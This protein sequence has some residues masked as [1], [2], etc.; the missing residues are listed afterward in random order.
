MVLFPTL[1]LLAPH[2]KLNACY[3]QVAPVDINSTQA[4]GECK[5]PASQWG[6]FY[7]YTT[8]GKTIADI[9]KEDPEWK[10]AASKI[11]KF[12]QD[13]GQK[14]IDYKRFLRCLKHDNLAM[15]YELPAANRRVSNWGF[16]HPLEDCVV[17]VE[18]DQEQKKAAEV[19]PY[20]EEF[21]RKLTRNSTVALL[22]DYEG[23]PMKN[24]TTLDSISQF[25]MDGPSGSADMQSFQDVHRKKR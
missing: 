16:N 5:V 12:V 9:I 14:R 22:Q 11:I 6:R 17:D 3:G 23:F 19:F 15:E 7:L 20:L 10:N 25:K 21:D 8:K 4:F 2:A 1:L 13:I 24:W 18:W